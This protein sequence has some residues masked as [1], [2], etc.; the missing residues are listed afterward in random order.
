MTSETSLPVPTSESKLPETAPPT[1][2]G[3]LIQFN[4]EDIRRTLRRALILAGAAVLVASP[5]LWAWLGWRTC[6][7][8]VI[9]VAI[10]ATGI[11]EWLQ[12][13]SAMMSRMEEGRTPVPMGRVLVMFFLRLAVAGV[14]LYASLNSLHGS[15]YALL[16]GLAVSLLALTVESIRLVFR[17]G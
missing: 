14:L 7:T 6:L 8:F 10:S 12:L 16:A 9:G 11:V 4:E 15:V 1:P 2:A 13:L 5:V 17:T 3:S